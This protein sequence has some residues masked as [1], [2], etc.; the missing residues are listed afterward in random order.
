MSNFSAVEF[1]RSDLKKK[2]KSIIMNSKLL[3]RLFLGILAVS[4]G[5]VSCSGNANENKNIPEAQQ[6]NTA[7]R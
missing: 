3:K 5:S 7:A 6:V 1:N 4:L 2:K